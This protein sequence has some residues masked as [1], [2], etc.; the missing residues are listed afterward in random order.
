VVN[1]LADLGWP[2]LSNLGFSG[3]AGFCTGVA[4]KAR[5]R[6]V[7]PRPVP[8]TAAALHLVTTM[9]LPGSQAS[10]RQGGLGV[11]WECILHFAQIASILACPNAS[12]SRD[13]TD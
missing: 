2:L 8:S 5:N 10:G 12:A 11:C 1:G 13:P 9:S 4:L 6:H 7:S 3:A